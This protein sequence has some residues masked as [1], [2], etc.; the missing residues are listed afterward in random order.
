[1]DFNSFD[2]VST[3]MRSSMCGISNASQILFKWLIKRWFNIDGNN[4]KSMRWTDVENEDES[5]TNINGEKKGGR[6]GIN[7]IFLG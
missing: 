4:P 1:M 6:K 5:L 7:Y 3:S 2:I